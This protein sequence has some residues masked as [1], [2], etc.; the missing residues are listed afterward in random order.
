MVERFTYLTAL[1]R[2]KWSMAAYGVWE[3]ANDGARTNGGGIVGDV[4]LTNAASSFT[5]VYDHGTLTF[6]NLASSSNLTGWANDWQLSADAGNEEAGSS[7]SGND[8]GDAVYFGGAVPFSEIAL[9][10]GTDGVMAA[11]VWEWEV[12]TGVA[13][14]SLTLAID[15][16]DQANQDG[17]QAFEQ[18]GAISF[19]PPSD[20]ASTT[21]DGQA[22][23]WIRA[24]CVAEQITTTPLTNS[25]EHDI[26]T[27]A[28]GFTCPHGGIITGI[29]VIDSIAEGS[30]HSGSS[31]EFI[32]MNW[33]TG[34]HSAPS[35][36]PHEWA[37]NQR[38]DSFTGLTLAI[39]QGD[40][41]YPLV[42][43]EDSG[44][45]DPMNVIVELQVS[46]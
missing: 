13:W 46:G 10:L 17:E 26:V 18:S 36:V 11:K 16:T 27:P 30:E 14:G 42:T 44:D 4:T 8:D 6:A 24:R 22:A 32:L 5:K 12:F 33:T 20:W 19:I 40:V 21:V 3:L 34:A 15:N 31:V 1:K 9:D 35:D 38:Q 2:K 39:N 7:G 41:V 29:R 25:V 23:Y 37:V 28:D 43:Q 45:D